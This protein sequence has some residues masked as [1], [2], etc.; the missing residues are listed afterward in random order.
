M[1]EPR[2]E[3]EIRSVPFCGFETTTAS[4]PP[5]AQCATIDAVWRTCVPSDGVM[6]AVISSGADPG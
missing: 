2:G 1:T 4:S 5:R 6:Q 3:N